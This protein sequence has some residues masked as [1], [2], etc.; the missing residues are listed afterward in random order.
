MCR[1]I[2]LYSLR[3]VSSQV[4]E[5][6]L[7]FLMGTASFRF[8]IGLREVLSQSLEARRSPILPGAPGIMPQGTGEGT[9]AFS[10]CETFGRGVQMRPA[11]GCCA[12]RIGYDEPLALRVRP[13]DHAQ[14]LTLGGSCSASDAGPDGSVA[15][16]RAVEL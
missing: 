6:V 4:H 11:T 15:G 14:Q 13:C 2:A 10:E 1:L 3:G 8:S 12:A 5:Q 7:P 16:G 9:P